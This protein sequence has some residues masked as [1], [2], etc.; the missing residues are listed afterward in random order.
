[1]TPSPFLCGHHNWA[2]PMQLVRRSVIISK[3]L[4]S[5]STMSI[6]LLWER[7]IKVARFRTHLLPNPLYVLLI[8]RGIIAQILLLLLPL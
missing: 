4:P 6:C 7:A 2:L 5:A 8:I 3:R 1:M